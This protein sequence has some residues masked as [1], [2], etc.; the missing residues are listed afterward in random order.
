MN[1]YFQLRRDKI[2]NNGK[3]PIRMIIY[4]N[5]WKIFKN[6][7][8]VEVCLQDWDSRHYVIK[9]NKT[10]LP[11]N[12]HVEYN[13][14]I[15][16]KKAQVNEIHRD[17][18]LNDRLATKEEVLNRLAI[19]KN[20]SQNAFF[21][22]FD[23]FIEKN[24]NNYTPG[25]IK[26]YKT[27]R[28]FLL[29]FQKHLGTPIN[30]NNIDLLFYDNF[31]DYAVF[32]GYSNNYTSSLIKRF[33]HLMAWA[34]DRNFHNNLIFKKFVFKEFNIEVVYL[35]IEELLRL[36]HFDFKNKRLS[37][38]RDL[39]CF[40]SLTGLRYSDL[41]NLS[42]G[43]FYEDYFK[44]SI[45]K[46]NTPDHIIPLSDLAN[47]ILQKYKNTIHFPLPNISDVKLNKYIKECCELANINSMVSTTRYVGKKRIEKKQPKF[48]LV[49]T[50][51]ARKTFV[52]NSLVL[53]M[54]AHVIKEITGHK[55]EA[56]FVK[57][58]NI[59]ENHKQRELFLA[60]NE[61]ENKTDLK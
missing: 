32:L 1:L 8:K 16:Q 57:Y 43:E 22:L 58:L 38:A 54:P 33:K 7:K 48:E 46:T 53:G 51:T 21:D 28:R 50:H 60:W 47:S 20:Q 24:L 35:T 10:N 52:T 59:S 23:F 5:G 4:H 44:I 26:N 49:S 30:L 12:F 61:I 40:A 25:T 42:K 36:Y 27:T 55:S 34:Y 11:Y 18:L 31:I 2:K 6:V 14:I 45:K 56:S 41:A 13:K 37:K 3:F 19:K 9:Q 15:E 29:K 39:F 17:L